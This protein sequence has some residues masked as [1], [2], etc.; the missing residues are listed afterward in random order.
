MATRGRTRS[1]LNEQAQLQQFIQESQEQTI[2]QDA[3]G[4]PDD[5]GTSRKKGRRGT[6]KG[7]SVQNQRRRTGK[8]EVV[9]HPR[10]KRVVGDNARHFKT[11]ACVTLKQYAPLKYPYFKDIP[12]ENKRKMWLAMKQKFDLQDNSQT[13]AVFFKQLNRQYRNRRHKLHSYYKDHKY[14]ENVLNQPPEGVELSDWELLI[15]YFESEE[16]RNVSD[17]NS[18][19]RAKLKML[20]TCGTKSIAQYCY[21]D[22]DTETGVEPTRTDTLKKTHFSTKKNDW[23]DKES[24]DAY[25]KITRLQN[26]ELDDNHEPMNED[27]AFIEALGPEKSGRLRGCGDGL[28]PPSK[29]GQNISEEVEKENEELR[30]KV[31]EDKECMKEMSSRIE[32][33]ESQANSQEAQ[34]QAQVQAYLKNQF[35]AFFQSLGNAGQTHPH[36]NV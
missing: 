3:P 25:D 1:Q 28:K 29:K 10:R 8:L 9:I 13:K 11:E 21:E 7:I 12:F 27:E 23:V 31:E 32:A 35:P 2:E 15:N 5:I 30:K 33:L 26:P 36:A 34:V 20:H 16:F 18:E 17:R 14:D 6:T 19:N 24:K 22:R 4:Q